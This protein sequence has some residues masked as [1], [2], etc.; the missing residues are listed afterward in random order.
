MGCFA[1]A[2]G[3]EQFRIAWAML[4]TTCV[5]GLNQKTNAIPQARLAHGWWSDWNDPWWWIG[6]RNGSNNETRIGSCR[7]LGKVQAQGGQLDI[8]DE[9]NLANLLGDI[10]QQPSRF[11]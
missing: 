5:G 11:M 9:T 7:L 10:Y 4:L 3:G 1:G 8:V 6:C 2:A